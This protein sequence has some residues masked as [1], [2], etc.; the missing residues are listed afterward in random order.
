MRNYINNPLNF[1]ALIALIL[2][3]A[4]SACSKGSDEESSFV[5]VTATS[6]ATGWTMTGVTNGSISNN[7]S[8][9]LSGRFSIDS[10]IVS[11]FT[12]A[13]CTGSALGTGTVQSGSFTISSIHLSPDATY[14]F[15]YTLQDSQGNTSS[16]QSTGLSYILD[17]T[18]RAPTL[19]S[20]PTYST[21]N[22]LNLTIALCNDSEEYLVASSQPSAS[23]SGWTACMENASITFNIVSEGSNLLKIWGRKLG[24][25]VSSTPTS[26]TIIRDTL[27]PPA[28]S[29]WTMSSPPNGSTSTDATPMI[30]GTSTEDGDT[31]D[32]FTSSSC[33]SPSKVG[34]A[35]VT[36]GAFSIP[37]F[38]LAQD[39]SYTFYYQVRDPAGNT[40]ACSSTSLSYV[41]DTSAPTSPSVVINSGETG[42]EFHSVSLTLSATETASL[43]M[44]MCVAEDADCSTCSWISYSSTRNMNLSAGNGSKTIS[45]RFRDSLGNT[46]SCVH[47]SITVSGLSVSP[48]YTAAPNWNTYV[49]KS[50]TSQ[51]CDGSETS[52]SECIHG[53]DAL[54]VLSS[55]ATCSGYTMTDALGVFDWNCS[56][57]AGLAIFD[58]SLKT[59][60]GLKDLVNATSWKSNSV[61][62]TS[63]SLSASSGSSTW[64]SNT[65]QALPSNPSSSVATL[66][67]ANTIYTLAS[68]ATTAGYNIAASGIAIVTLGSSVLSWNGG[69]AGVA[70]NCSSVDGTTVLPDLRCIIASSPQ[71]FLWIEGTIDG[72]SSNASDY[73]IFLGGVNFSRL[74]RVK[75]SNQASSGI[76]LDLGSNYN[77]FTG[78]TASN[79]GTE[80]IKLNGASVG[81]VLSTINTFNN[82]RNGINITSSGTN[83]LS[84]IFS[85]A[86]GVS[87]IFL[88]TSSSNTLSQIT[89]N[90]NATYGILLRSSSSNIISNAITANNTT[91]SGLTVSSNFNTFSQI[92][93]TNNTTGISLDSSS[94]NKFT[95]NL[96]VGSNST[97]NCSVNLGTRPGLVNSTCTTTGTSGSATYPASVASDAILLTGIDTSTSFAGKIS[98]DGTNPDGSAGTATYSSS[99]NW[100]DFANSSRSWGL[101][102][103]AF[104]NSNNRGRCGS[105][106]CR[107]WDWSIS[108]SDSFLRNLSGDGITPNDP[109]LSNICPIQ[110]DGNHFITDKSGTVTFLA[111]AYELLTQSSGN[112]NGL[113]E[114]GETCIYSPNFGAY[115]GH[116]S[117]QTCTFSSGALTGITLY[118]Y[119]INGR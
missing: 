39:G 40:L 27:P 52:T 76:L 29:S 43:P 71:S 95:G 3:T 85:S 64:W 53:G 4:L 68:S 54:R 16:C 30:S 100:V 24:T 22:T 66:S 37:N 107:I 41:L 46:S 116:S 94:N 119:S 55:H 105:G 80:G 10:A 93:S 34:T 101:D 33:T 91:G 81:N 23:T 72:G 67:S 35:T 20:T 8:P 82:L 7:P 18:P 56:L 49:K 97:S 25:V 32:L 47:S 38:T 19:V 42:T 99:L 13:N 59:G 17:T 45:A 104:P 28:V 83:I 48:R 90:N 63:G 44:Q 75:V 62:L 102:G 21:S 103:S 9:V 96:L 118:W 86:N 11:V 92:V 31:V 2:V 112:H 88:N 89:A 117:L 110:V 50:N 61:T 73:G 84:E 98:S 113:C 58:S 5:P 26:F 77:T 6:A 115:Q 36:S 12:T 65:V 114:S 108:T 15:Y 51:A 1:Q 78:V 109:I 70:E 111:S 57:V 60:K 74:H 106:N 69:A 79:N 87:G 14:A